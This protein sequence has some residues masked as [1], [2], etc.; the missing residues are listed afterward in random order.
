MSLL[1][2][3]LCVQSAVRVLQSQKYIFNHV[4][5]ESDDD[6]ASEAT[7]GGEPTEHP[8][9]EVDE[10][11]AAGSKSIKQAAASCP[12]AAHAAHGMSADA[13]ACPFMTAS[14]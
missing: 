9:F 7:E 1:P 4:V 8:P 6:R 3:L 10:A 12:F 2:A 13:S 5:H 14:K 11:P